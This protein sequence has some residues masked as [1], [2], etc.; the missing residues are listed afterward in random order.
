MF[1]RGLEDLAHG[2]Q[3]HRIDD[4]HLAG[5]RCP[6]S[7][8][9]LEECKQLSLGGRLAR[10]QLHVRHGKFTGMGVRPADGGGNLHGWVAMQR[11][12]DRQGIDVVPTP[13]DQFLL[14]ASQ[15]EVAFFI[16]PRE[17]ARIEPTDAIAAFD[18]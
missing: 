2:S 8:L 1:E 18:P 16:L 3:R 17:V 9:R 15:P 14:A 5:Q 7:N 11:R 12:L 4:V 6:L 10:S 13:D